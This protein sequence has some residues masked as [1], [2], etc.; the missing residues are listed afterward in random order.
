[1]KF[2]ALFALGLLTATHASVIMVRDDPKDLLN[3]D[4]VGDPKGDMPGKKFGVQVGRD[5]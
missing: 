5:R 4:C 2:Q 1:M 3:Y